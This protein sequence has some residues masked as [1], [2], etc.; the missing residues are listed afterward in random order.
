MALEGCEALS[1]GEARA[2][3]GMLVSDARRI[4]FGWPIPFLRMNLSSQAELPFLLKLSL[5]AALEK[6]RAFSLT[7]SPV[8]EM[9]I[10]WALRR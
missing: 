6:R 8:T 10:F 2:L 9:P 1:D 5:P 4:S 3:P 7:S